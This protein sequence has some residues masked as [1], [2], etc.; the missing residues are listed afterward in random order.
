MTEL[1]S[2][3]TAEP[4]TSWASADRRGPGH[5]LAHGASGN[6]H[7]HPRPRF[8][9]TET[10][11]RERFMTRFVTRKSGNRRGS[12]QLLYQHRGLSLQVEAGVDEDGEHY[13][14]DG[15]N[16]YVQG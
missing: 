8:G 11:I 16:R 10:V 2:T 4:S 7:A 12:R 1:T 13:H 15:R 5:G 9:M 14:A 3:A 6:F